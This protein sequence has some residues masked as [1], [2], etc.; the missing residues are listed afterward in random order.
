[1]A[2]G[3][4]YDNLLDVWALGITLYELCEGHPPY[5][6]KGDLK[7]IALVASKASPTLKNPSL[8]SKDCQQF[9]AL[10]LEQNVAKRPT[11]E[12][13]MKH[14]WVKTCFKSIVGSSGTR[15][16]KEYFDSSIG[17]IMAL[18]REQDDSSDESDNE[19]DMKDILAE[20][21]EA[22]VRGE[23]EAARLHIEAQEATRLLV[24]KQAAT[25]ILI[26]KQAAAKLREEV[27]EEA[28]RR[29][30]QRDLAEKLKLE[31]EAALYQAEEEEAT[32][33]FAAER[34][35]AL[36]VGSDNDDG[37]LTSPVPCIPS[38]FQMLAKKQNNS[39]FKMSNWKG[40]YF[41]L[42]GGM[43]SYF[44]SKADY[45]HNKALKEDTSAKISIKKENRYDLSTH[46]TANLHPTVGAPHVVAVS[47]SSGA[48]GGWSVLVKC[49]NEASCNAWVS[50]V[51]KQVKYLQACEDYK[52]VQKT[53]PVSTISGVNVSEV[54][55]SLGKTAT[56]AANVNKFINKLRESERD[57]QKVALTRLNK[58]LT[59]R[60]GRADS[61]LM[62]TEMNGWAHKKTDHSHNWKRRHFVLENATM[63][64][65]L[66]D[67]NTV[68][69]GIFIFTP[70]STVIKGD[71]NV[72]TVTHVIGT[73]DGGKSQLAS[74]ALAIKVDDDAWVIET[75]ALALQ[76]N[77][78]H[79][80]H[81]KLPE[82]L[83]RMKGH[84]KYDE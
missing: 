50:N 42:D 81:V 49:E 24:E 55:P 53:G 75:W 3:Q 83:E 8:W 76:D 30:S 43:L 38:C 66:T 47:D 12:A 21:E 34:A 27:Q 25:R 13:L 1:M 35:A 4:S 59:M 32:A 65:F 9:L 41:V 68:P 70:L 80:K 61:M 20:E 17:P 10:C 39:A 18:R 29:K 26:E 23:E 72:I 63:K 71:G 67:K 15:V 73:H 14:T 19:H 79:S 28:I 58:R 36:V 6:N 31:E 77:I 51:E 7:V 64:Y 45:L 48:G 84:H 33:R 37:T 69:Q 44:R 56:T 2:K 54:K 52:T 16:L 82:N 60:K 46:C 40:A 74:S 62:P 11:V 57:Q 22:R 78:N 5:A